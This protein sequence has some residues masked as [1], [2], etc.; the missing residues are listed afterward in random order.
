[1]LDLHTELAPSRGYLLAYFIG[2]LV[3]EPYEIVDGELRFSGS[4]SL[5]DAR[6]IEC[7]LFDSAKE[8]RMVRRDS[9]DDIVECVLTRDEEDAMDPSLIFV[10]EPLVRE[11]F[12]KRQGLPKRVR[13]VSRY[14]YTPNDTLVLRNYRIAT[15]E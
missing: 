6:P 11:E 13:V 9:S 4:A 2:E 14:Q 15:A 10:E 1:M 5:A 8:Y 3:F 12:A 7:H